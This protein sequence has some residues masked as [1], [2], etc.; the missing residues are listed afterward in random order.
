MVAPLANPLD[1]DLEEAWRELARNNYS[2]YLE[3]SHRGRWIPAKHHDLITDALEKV[4]RGEI[5]RLM[6]FMPPR[7]GKSMAVSESFPSYYLGK[8]PTRRVIEVSYSESLAKKFGR[9]NRQK[10]DEFGAELFG[11]S[12][13]KENGSVTDW[14]VTS[15]NGETIGGM[16]SRGVGGG[17][18]GQGAD[19]LIIDD[20]IRNR[21]DADSETYRNF[22]WNEWNDTLKTRLHPGGAVIVILTRWHEDDL[23]GRL[24]AEDPESWTVI[25]LPAEAEENDILGRN[26]GDPLWPE[27]GFDKTWLED[28]KKHTDPR[29]WASLYQ[30]RPSPQEGALIKRHW[31]KYY[32]PG[33]LPKF[34]KVIQSWDMTFNDAEQSDFVAGQVWAKSGADYYVLDRVKDRMDF[35]ASCEA[36]KALS[37]KWPTARKKLIENKANGPAVI[38]ALRRQISGF[39][40]V[41]PLGSKV[42]RV[43]SVSYLISGGNVYLP[44]P[45]TAPW[46]KEFIEEWA[47]F[48][49]GVHDD[50]VDCGSQALMELEGLNNTKGGLH[51][52]HV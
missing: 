52:G 23:A 6:F 7:H 36:V 41:N 9:R 31:W 44:H 42:S 29:T 46:V 32:M 13:S 27:H 37:T 25:S 38:S 17:I 30:Q 8:K 18:T 43:N 24:L 51:I 4:E 11:I 20:P 21:R 5:K 49:N 22:L 19:L 40:P 1:L 39:H 33:Q 28:T 2:F 34:D 12:I 35:L 15:K 45:S 47:V 10:I 48:P 14:D 50:E 16:I 3:Y 26:V